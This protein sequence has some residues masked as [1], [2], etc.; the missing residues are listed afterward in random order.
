[1]AQHFLLRS[2]LLEV[3]SIIFPQL[4]KA[5]TAPLSTEPYEIKTFDSTMGIF[6]LSTATSGVFPTLFFIRMFSTLPAEADSLILVSVLSPFESRFYFSDN[7]GEH[8]HRIRTK[9]K[10]STNISLF[11]GYQDAGGRSYRPIENDAKNGS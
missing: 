11:S 8:I 4:Y 6:L 5:K 1:M 7:Y 2:Y 3:I 9:K 10:K